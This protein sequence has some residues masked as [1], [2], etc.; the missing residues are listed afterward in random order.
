MASSSPTTNGTRCDETTT[1]TIAATIAA[2]PSAKLSL[3]MAPT[4]G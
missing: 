3:S 1:A 2:S 4:T